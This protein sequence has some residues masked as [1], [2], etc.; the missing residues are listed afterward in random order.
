MKI[1]LLLSFLMVVL[2]YSTSYASFPVKRSHTTTNNTEVTTTSSTVDVL[3][4]IATVAAK[5]KWVGVAL[6]FFLGWPFAAHRWYYKKPVLYNILFIVTLG[7]L[8]IWAIID[9]IN[10]LTDNF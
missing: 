5:D 4:P 7:G 2:M 10:I 9:L 1:K 3:T 8:G 6:W